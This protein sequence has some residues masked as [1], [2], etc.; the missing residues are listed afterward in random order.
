MIRRIQPWL[1]ALAWAALIFL[2]SSRPSVP[3]DLALGR[4]KLAHFLAYAVLGVL[5]ARGQSR[6]GAPVAAAYA[7]GVAYGASDEWHQSFVPGRA[8]ELGDF[9]AD[10][11]GVIAGV[12]LY[13]WTR[14]RV[15]GAT[16]PPGGAR[17]HTRAS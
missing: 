17:T 14:R 13:H 8:S 1:P 11:A 10:A 7:I 3:V 9:I 16:A 5:L 6:S 12:S 2:L 15:R 4:D